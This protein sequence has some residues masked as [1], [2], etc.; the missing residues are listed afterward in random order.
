MRAEESLTQ[1][2]C[3]YES[4]M[5]SHLICLILLWTSTD[6]I[7]ANHSSCNRTTFDD[8]INSYCVSS[9]HHS[10]ESV[11]YK[12]SCPWPTTKRQYYKLSRCVKE[13][14]IHTG[15]NEPHLQ[16]IMFLEIHRVYFNPCPWSLW[17]DPGLPLLLALIMPCIITTLLMPFLCAH[18]TPNTREL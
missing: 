1:H 6:L 5:E 17:Q 18:V 8:Y 4:R 12:E 3:E 14:A 7:G 9:F 16:D 11:N 2:A 10:M 15:C 13:V